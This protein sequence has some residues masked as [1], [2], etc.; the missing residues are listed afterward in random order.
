MKGTVFE[1]SACLM[2]HP[3]FELCPLWFP[4]YKVF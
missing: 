2:E 4:R 3:Q 1:N